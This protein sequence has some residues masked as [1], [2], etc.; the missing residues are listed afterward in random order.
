MSRSRAF[1]ERML[2]SASTKRAGLLPYAALA[3]GVAVVYVAHSL[4]VY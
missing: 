1:L 4:A 2:D 3:A